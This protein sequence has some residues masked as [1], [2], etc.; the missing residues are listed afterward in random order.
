M[1]T[2]A[3]TIS[4]AVDL[5]KKLKGAD[6]KIRMIQGRKVELWARRLKDM[7]RTGNFFD[8]PTPN[9]Q[10]RV[11]SGPTRKDGNDLV[12]QAGWGSS[13]GPILEFGVTPKNQGGWRISANQT[14]GEPSGNFA[15]IKAFTG[16]R[17]LR[18]QIGSRI[19][20]KSSVWHPWNYGNQGSRPHWVRVLED[21]RKRI[22]ADLTATVGEVFTHG[23]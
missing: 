19:V 12:A 17:K 14:R 20:Y 10:Q 21:N 9:L 13:Y 6:R 16:R 5:S 23:R 7:V 15:D 22:E 8:D 11:W 4:G 2:A 1:T 18:F 3:V